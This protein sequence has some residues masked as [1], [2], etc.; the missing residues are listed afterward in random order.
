M[1][2]NTANTETPLWKQGK[3]PDLKFANLKLLERQEPSVYEL[4]E[5]MEGFITQDLNYSYKVGCFKW[6]LYLSRM[7]LGQNI[8]IPDMT[9]VNSQNTDLLAE[10]TLNEFCRQ[11][12]E[13]R[14]EVLML[15]RKLLSK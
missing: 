11:I 6:V 8:A 14:A 1:S 15:R 2:N 7:K 4:I 5:W 12:M 9:E 10:S 13:L 3:N